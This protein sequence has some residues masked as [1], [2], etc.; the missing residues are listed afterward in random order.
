MVGLGGMRGAHA[1]SWDWSNFDVSLLDKLSFG[2]FEDRVC[3]E[4]PCRFR[5]LVCGSW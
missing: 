3:S 5:V 4:G 2:S 1:T